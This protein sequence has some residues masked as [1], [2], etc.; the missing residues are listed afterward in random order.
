MS[1]HL[2]SKTKIAQELRVL[3]YKVKSKLFTELTFQMIATLVFLLNFCPDLVL[4]CISGWILL[5]KFDA[6]SFQFYIV[7]AP[8]VLHS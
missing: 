5:K 4:L 3:V 2:S 8:I 1:L 6:L 7:S